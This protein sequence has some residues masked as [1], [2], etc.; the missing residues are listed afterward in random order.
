MNFRGAVRRI[1]SPLDRARLI[2]PS[3][4]TLGEA[5]GLL[6]VAS[7]LVYRCETVR[8]SSC[9]QNPVVLRAA[10]WHQWPESYCK[11][12]PLN[13][14]TYP[15]GCGFLQVDDGH[16]PRCHWEVGRYSLRVIGVSGTDHQ[17]P[18]KTHIGDSLVQFTRGDWHRILPRKIRFQMHHGAFAAALSACSD[19]Y[20]CFH[21]CGYLCNS[22]S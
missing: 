19:T 14:E 22:S 2:P 6:G 11:C 10:H 21:N 13:D 9:H 17:K 5:N 1:L 20:W 7:Y 12:S 4:V 3:L 8:S 16:S 18:T 15:E